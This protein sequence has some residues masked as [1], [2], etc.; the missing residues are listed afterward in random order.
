MY[1][2]WLLSSLTA[3]QLQEPGRF[4]KSTHDVHALDGLAARALDQVVFGTHDHHFPGPRI[5]APGDLDGIR[6]DHV[7]GVGKRW[8]F[9]QSDKRLVAVGRFIALSEPILQSQALV[10][11]PDR[12]RRFQV[13]RGQDTAIHRDEVR[14]ELDDDLSAG[15]ERELFLDFRQMA[16]LKDAVRPDTLIALHEHIIEFGLPPGTA[17]TT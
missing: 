10:R 3:E 16:M 12:G 11:V 15:G 5:S 2:S 8:P 9:E 7:L 13:E 17:D 6:S 14:R 1:F 4:R